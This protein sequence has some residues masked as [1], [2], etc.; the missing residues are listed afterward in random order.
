MVRA[1]RWS[2]PTT[3]HRSR[4]APLK[5]SAGARGCAGSGSN[6]GVSWESPA[7]LRPGIPKCNSG[8]DSRRTKGVVWQPARRWPSDDD[9][10][11]EADLHQLGRLDQAAGDLLVRA[12]GAGIPRGMVV[13]Q[14][15]AK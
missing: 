10:V 13:N 8:D 11:E 14:D 6:A 4:P 12:A 3:G 15:K 7:V 9:V 5:S 2:S 1:N